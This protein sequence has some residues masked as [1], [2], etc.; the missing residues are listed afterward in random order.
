MSPRVDRSSE[1][2]FDSV[3]CAPTDQLA[4][5]PAPDGPP[6]ERASA[7]PTSVPDF[8]LVTLATGCLQGRNAVPLDLFVPVRTAAATPEL[9]LRA[10][11]LLLHVDG[12]S[13]ISAIAACVQLPLDEVVS[14]FFCL[15]ALGVV[16]MTG[17]AADVRA[18]C[19]GVFRR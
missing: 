15:V 14:V 19:S 11:F 6:S 8:D 1:R 16:E 3:V 5:V 17:P 4:T 13:S 12:Q 2:A 7:R 10:A 9:G 18:P